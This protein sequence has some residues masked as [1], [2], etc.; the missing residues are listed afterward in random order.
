MMPRLVMRRG[1]ARG[2]GGFGSCLVRSCCGSTLPKTKGIPAIGRAMAEVNRQSVA[3]CQIADADGEHQRHE[4]EYGEHGRPLGS[5]HFAKLPLRSRSQSTAQ[6][7]ATETVRL[8][9]LCFQ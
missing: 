5:T 6:T 3:K 2:L 1:V 7:Y 9:G 4:H 8:C